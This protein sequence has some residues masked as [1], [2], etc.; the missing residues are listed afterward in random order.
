MTEL[1]IIT[2]LVV[3][4]IIVISVIRIVS[5][6][7][8]NKRITTYMAY[9]EALYSDIEERVNIVRKYR[10][11]LSKHICMLEILTAKD[12]DSKELKKYIREHRSQYDSVVADT[13]TGDDIL[14]TLIHIKRVECNGKNIVLNISVESGCCDFLDETDKVGLLSNLLDNAIEATERLP[15]GSKHDI[16]L[17]LYN[18]DNNVVVKLTNSIAKGKKLSFV[19][20][21]RD[22]IIHGIGTKVIEDIIVKYNGSR[23][24]NIDEANGVLKDKIVLV[25]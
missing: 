12:G 2:S 10:H 7:H 9:M 8:E 4:L 19:T 11:D 18:E 14:D 13:D 15:K 25:R 23:E 3:F 22:K 1:M 21:K 6:K 24:L 5:I 16:S 17:D 20:Q